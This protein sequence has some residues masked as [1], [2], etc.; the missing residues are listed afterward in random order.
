MRTVNGRGGTGR[1]RPLAWAR[2]RPIRVQHGRALPGE[3]EPTEGRQP[4]P[5]L[6][7]LLAGSCKT[8]QQKL[9]RSEQVSLTPSSLLFCCSA[10]ELGA[11]VPDP[12]G[13][14]R[15]NLFPCG[16]TPTPTYTHRRRTPTHSLSLPPSLR[17]T[18]IPRPRTECRRRRPQRTAVTRVSV[19]DTWHPLH[20]PQ[21]SAGHRPLA[22]TL[23]S[24]TFL[25]RART[26][27]GTYA[28]R[29]PASLFLLCV[30][31]RPRRVCGVDAAAAVGGG[32]ASAHVNLKQQ[33]LGLMA[34]RA[35]GGRCD[36]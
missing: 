14:E 1:Q 11:W 27:Q 4:S 20:S 29:L 8:I 28:A 7:F 16:H 3:R 23:L 6:I 30:R 36:G 2:N 10:V 12:N 17:R 18:H 21:T 19:H 31:R 5:V 33:T 25:L 15:S 9:L 24:T 32:A 34:R 26:I 13:G 22:S 35:D